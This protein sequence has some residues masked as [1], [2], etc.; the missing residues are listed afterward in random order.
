MPVCLLMS[1]IYNEPNNCSKFDLLCSC[2]YEFFFPICF[3][4]KAAKEYNNVRT[5]FFTCA[6]NRHHNFLLCSPTISVYIL[7]YC[8]M[9]LF[10]IVVVIFILFFLYFLHLSPLGLFSFILHLSL[11]FVRLLV[12]GIS[13]PK[14]ST[15]SQGI[16]TNSLLCS[17]L[18]KY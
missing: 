13:P 17:K 15:A 7:L 9:L 11:F 4:F 14:N 12:C 16:T 18:H 3:W 6:Y 1:A 5:I 2:L 8:I 10:A